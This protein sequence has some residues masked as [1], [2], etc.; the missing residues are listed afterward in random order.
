VDI[1][2]HCAS[3]F[4]DI[5]ALKYTERVKMPNIFSKN[6]DLTQLWHATHEMFAESNERTA[7]ETGPED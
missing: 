1:F 4:A 2:A 6:Q 5:N 3:L 7:M